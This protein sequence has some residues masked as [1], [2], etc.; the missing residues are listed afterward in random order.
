MYHKG[1]P[2]VMKIFNST[3]ASLVFQNRHIN[4]AHS[5]TDIKLHWCLSFLQFFM[6]NKFLGT[7]N[8]YY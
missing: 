8:A 1:T 3:N 2:V 5:I 6:S 4:G 7:S